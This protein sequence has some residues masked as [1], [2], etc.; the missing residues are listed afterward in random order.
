M[1]R[2]GSFNN[3]AENLRSANRNRNRPENRNQNIGFRC[4]RG[5]RR[6]HAATLA[7]CR[8]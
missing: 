6:Q 5:P 1:L 3:P 2:G 8:I 7:P 4:V